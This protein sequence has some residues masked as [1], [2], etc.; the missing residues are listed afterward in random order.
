[1][2]NCINHKHPDIVKMA[3]ELNISPVV[4]A[5]KIGVWQEKNNIIDRFP[6]IEEIQK[7]QEV[8]YGLKSLEI[9][10]SD[11]AKQIFEKGNKNNWSLDK[12]LTELQVPK[13]QKQLI[14]DLGIKSILS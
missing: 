5:A 4:L 9:L 6:T 2:A 13:E 8:N 14:L 1:M 11:K 10:S 12:I 7:P 3:G